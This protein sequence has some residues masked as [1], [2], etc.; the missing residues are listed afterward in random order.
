M[1]PVFMGSISR[2]DIQLF[3]SC[4]PPEYSQSAVD[5]D[6]VWEGGALQDWHRSYEDTWMSACTHN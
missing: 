4:L 1:Q 6:N 5:P 2:F 3:M